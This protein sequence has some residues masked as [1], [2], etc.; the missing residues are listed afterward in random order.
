MTTETR[1]LTEMKDVL[2]VEIECPECQL[3]I[4]YPIAKLFR[5]EPLCPH[6]NCDWF[7]TIAPEWAE[8]CIREDRSG[9]RYGA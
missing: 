9:S 2:G 7:E 6:C 3:T 1:T 5:I 8:T 4:L